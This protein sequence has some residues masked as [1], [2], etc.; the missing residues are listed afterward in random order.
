[1]NAEKTA[2]RESLRRQALALGKDALIRSDELLFQN[3]SSLPEYRDARCLFLFAGVGIEPDTWKLVETLLA[4]K[5]NVALP[6]IK[7]GR[8]MDVCLITGKAGLRAGYSGILEPDPAAP[9]LSL[10]EIDFVLVPAICYD[11]FGYRLGQGGGY[12]DRW[13]DGYSGFA[14]GLCRGV[15]LQER[16]PREN[17][18]RRVDAVITETEILRPA[19]R[20]D[21]LIG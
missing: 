1:M 11:R 14:A 9:A 16:L 6:R 17:H 4:E 10:E 13:L 19:K 20:D 8:E 7:P 5:R 15:F 18:D 2:L 3:L 12:Y 21:C